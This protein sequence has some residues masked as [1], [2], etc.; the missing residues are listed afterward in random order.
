MKDNEQ[1][2]GGGICSV[3]REGLWLAETTCNSL[4][5]ILQAEHTTGNNTATTGSSPCWPIGR[6][7]V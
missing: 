2:G 6:L 4:A 5:H 7:H 1:K 3:G